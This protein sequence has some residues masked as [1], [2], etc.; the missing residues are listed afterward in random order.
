MG[1]TMIV[2]EEFRSRA[3]LAREV[4]ALQWGRRCSSTERHEGAGVRGSGP[5]AS[6]GPAMFDRR[7]ES[8]ACAPPSP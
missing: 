1:H 4:H 2:D 6:M 3:V 8:I 7:R 5:C